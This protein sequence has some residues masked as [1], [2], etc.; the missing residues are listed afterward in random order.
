[1]FGKKDSNNSNDLD[2]TLMKTLCFEQVD[3]YNPD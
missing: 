2:G 3:T 1:M